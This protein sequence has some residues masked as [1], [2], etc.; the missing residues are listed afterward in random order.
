[1]G[2]DLPLRDIHLPDPVG[3]W[4]P[5]PG[6]WLLLIGVL[7]LIASAVGLWRF[8]RRKTTKKLALAELAAIAGS[9]AAARE[10]VQALAILLRRTALSVYP[11]EEVA[12][13]VGTQW[14]EFLDRTL[15]GNGFSEGEGRLLIEGPYRREMQG[16]LSALFEL[17]R[18]WIKRL[19]GPGKRKPGNRP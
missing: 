9:D 15:G 4:P 2:S 17:C 6:W 8:L 19:P 10:K 16:D 14:L 5:A 7:A 3:G 13:L 11:R 18:A 12:G 1:M